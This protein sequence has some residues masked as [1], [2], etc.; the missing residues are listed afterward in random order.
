[1]IPMLYQPFQHWVKC[2]NIYLLSDLHFGDSDCKLMDENW[3]LPEEQI[4]IINQTVGANDCFVCLG[5]VGNPNYIPLIKARNKI[6]ILGNHDK[7]G[8]CTLF[9]NEVYDGPLFIAPK[10]LLSHEPVNG[11]PWC[12]NIHGHDHSNA[13]PFDIGCY[14]LNLAANVCGYKPISLKQIIKEGF[15]SNIKDIHRTTIDKQIKLKEERLKGENY[16]S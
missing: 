10:I 7:K 14:H 3:V 6:L 4:K 13:E 11:L 16:G 15:L 1:M 5:D 8:L 12:Y 2:G 9:F